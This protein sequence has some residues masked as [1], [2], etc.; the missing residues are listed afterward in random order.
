MTVRLY[1]YD[2]PADAQ[3][4]LP[5]THSRP[6]GELRHGAW[7]LR[8]RCADVTGMP[9]TGHLAAAHLAAFAEPGSPPV[10]PAPDTAA[11]PCALLRST[12]I[13]A[14][15]ELAALGDVAAPRRLTDAQ[16]ATVGAALPRGHSWKG[17]SSIA[18]SWPAQVIPG[19]RLAGVWQLVG[20]L[21]PTL[22]TD[23]DSVRGAHLP[24]RTPAGCT[25][26]GDPAG[27]IVEEGVQ[28]EPFVVLDLR[29]GPIWI[30]A[31]AE[32]RSFSRL[33][34]PLVVGAGTRIVGG[35]L[36]D[37]SL[38]PM[39]VV[40]GEVSNTVFLGYA[41]KAHDG[42]VGHTIVG[43]WANL[44]AGT[45]TSNLKNTYG[46]VRLTLGGARHETGLTFLGSLVGDHVKTAI[47]TMLPTGCAIGTGANLFGSR[48]PEAVVAPFAWGNDA[49]ET[50]TCRRFLAV[51]ERV[52]PRRGVAVDDATRAYLGAVWQAATG[53]AGCD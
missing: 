30:Q 50:L 46:P 8:E 26:L 36:K 51:A 9:V 11:E 37:A 1:L 14:G 39:C 42:F 35:Q 2:D 29:H 21:V 52:L 38:G 23:L 31:G 40:H 45:T 22:R 6:I 13:P 15:R 24:T 4:F 44:G 20:D 17:A 41:N 19:T 34:G 10:V 16:G 47:G 3:L 32:V 18:A 53:T 27:L 48:R 25:I 28:V 43:R 12:F 33:S 5:F 49:L 7:T